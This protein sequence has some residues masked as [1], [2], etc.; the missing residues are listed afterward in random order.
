M[1]HWLPLYALIVWFGQVLRA[2]N[3]KRHS[4][5]TDRT[6]VIGLALVLAMLMKSRAKS[7]NVAHSYPPMCWR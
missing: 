3:R 5:F 2:Q 7:C 1:M 4:G 6:Y